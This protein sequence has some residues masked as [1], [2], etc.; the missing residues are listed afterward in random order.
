MFHRVGAT[1]P[2]TWPGTPHPTAQEWS[3]S[4]GLV[5][6][7]DPFGRCSCWRSRRNTA[8]G[9]TKSGFLPRKQAA[10]GWNILDFHFSYDSSVELPLSSHLKKH[11]PSI[12]YLPETMGLV[13]FSTLA[14]D[15]GVHDSLVSR[16]GYDK[17][18]VAVAPRCSPHLGQAHP[19]TDCCLRRCAGQ[20]RGNLGR[21]RSISWHMGFLKMGDTPKT[22]KTKSGKI[23]NRLPRADSDSEIASDGGRK[24]DRGSYNVL[25][26]LHMTQR[27]YCLEK[28][29]F[30]RNIKW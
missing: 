12:Y 29:F 5:L 23:Q 21:N 18:M 16:M 24:G 13:K 26:N 4:L 6:L 1:H 9:S 8:Y 27:A 10:D 15:F 20:R 19:G 28:T 17:S 2:Q 11:K 3:A 7:E 25:N 30:A 14:Q 22:L